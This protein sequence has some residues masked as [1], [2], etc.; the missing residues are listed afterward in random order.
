[1]IPSHLARGEH[2]IRIGVTE[3]ARGT[4]ATHWIEAGHVRID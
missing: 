4:I 1:M 3:L 2:P